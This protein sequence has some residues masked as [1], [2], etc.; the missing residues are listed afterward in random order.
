MEPSDIVMGYEVWVGVSEAVGGREGSEA[1]EG[2][3]VKESLCGWCTVIS[4]K[5]RQTDM[6]QEA[7]RSKTT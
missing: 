2:L 1:G 5:R 7:G 4:D 3:E 6:R